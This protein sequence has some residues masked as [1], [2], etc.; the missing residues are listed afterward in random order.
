MSFNLE[1]QPIRITDD[2]KDTLMER[3]SKG[4]E[5]PNAAD[6]RNALKGS[7]V[8]GDHLPYYIYMTVDSSGNILVFP[9]TGCRE[10]CENN[11]RVY[12]PEGRYL[13]STKI[14]NGKFKF[15]LYYENKNILFTESGIYGLFELKDT[16]DI[17]LRLVR[18]KLE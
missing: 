17:S 6:F 5:G 2:L 8:F 16:E 18:V 11:F 7:T 15:Q 1:Y 9:N 4:L 10:N 14:D 12:S 13:C 3:L